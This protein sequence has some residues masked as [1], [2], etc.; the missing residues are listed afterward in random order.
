MTP[1]EMQNS[2]EYIVNR[3]D[4]ELIINSAVIFHWLNEAQQLQVITHYTG[5]NPYQLGFEQN[6]KRTDD[7]RALIVESTIDV[8]TTS[9]SEKENGYTITLP[10]DYIFIVGEEATILYPTG[11]DDEYDTKIVEVYPITSDQYSKE[12]RSPYGRH[13]LHYENASPLRL[14]KENKVELITDGTY[15]VES[16]ILRYLRYPNTIELGGDDCELP[17]Y[18]HSHIIDKAVNLYLESIG[19]NRYSVNKAELA[20][21]E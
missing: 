7:L 15:S 14:M 4:S 2:F 17:E 20:D 11:I 10:T 12:V 19:D 21:K 8:D 5:N 13:K 9:S 6:Q 16:Y 3:Y 1:R 18:M